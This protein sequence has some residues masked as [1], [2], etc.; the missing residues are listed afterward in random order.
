MT[1][2]LEVIGLRKTFGATVALDDVSLA[3]PE[4]SIVGLLGPNG[5]GKT[6]LMKV[7]LGLVKA[8]AG[9]VRF[10]SSLGR[11]SARTV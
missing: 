1:A 8:D 9:Q 5:A 10:G 11:A 6:T 3:I 4:G 2:T 7:V